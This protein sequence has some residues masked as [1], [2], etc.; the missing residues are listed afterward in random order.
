MAGDHDAAGAAALSLC[1]ALL[2]SLADH[3]ILS[4]REILGILDDAAAA[5][6]APGQSAEATARGAATA[7]LIARIAPGGARPRRS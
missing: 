2:L 7:A 1:E 5:H 4:E 3:R 6:L